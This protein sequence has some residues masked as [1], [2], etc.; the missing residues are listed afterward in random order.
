MG[1]PDATVEV[2]SHQVMLCGNHSFYVLLIRLNQSTDLMEHV[3][4]G[5]SM[6]INE[7][8]DFLG[9]DGIYG[10]YAFTSCSELEHAKQ[11]WSVQIGIL[12]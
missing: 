8:R 12:L 4:S 6:A 1:V 7:E 10:G 9:L 5:K 3:S 2:F 11:N